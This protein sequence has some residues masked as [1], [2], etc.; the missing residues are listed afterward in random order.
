MITVG[1]WL[2]YALLVFAIYTSTAGYRARVEVWKA[3]ERQRLDHER[4]LQAQDLQQR[5]K[6]RQTAA[7]RWDVIAQLGRKL[8][9]PS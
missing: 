1:L 3:R 5:A 6:D 4:A 8:G 2:L 7:A 9:G